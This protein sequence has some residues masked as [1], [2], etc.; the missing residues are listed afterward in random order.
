LLARMKGVA[1]EDGSQVALVLIPLGVQLS[2]RQF[3]E[4]VSQRS[5]GAAPAQIDWPQQEMKGLARRAGVDVID[6]LPGFREWAA[7]GGA[8]LYLTRDGHWDR[9]GHRL[10][11]RI[12]ASDLVRLGL[13]RR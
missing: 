11:A 10:A 9:P 8:P 2:D 4:F 13:A 6:L 7:S 1:T 12:V 3:A 5:D